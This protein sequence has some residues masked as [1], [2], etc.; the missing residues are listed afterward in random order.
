MSVYYEIVDVFNSNLILSFTL[1]SSRWVLNE[2]PSLRAYKKR[3]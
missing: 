2:K 3:D 1:L